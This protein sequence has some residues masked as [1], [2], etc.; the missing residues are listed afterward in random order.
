MKEEKKMTCAVCIAN[1]E[2]DNAAVLTM[3]HYGHPRLLCKSCEELIE[4]ALR[5]KEPTEAEAAM[6]RLGE[7]VGNNSI[8][9]EAVTEA[10]EDVFK[11]ATERAE[12]IKNGTYDFAL[13]EVEDNSFDEIP[14]E[15]LET[16]EE[17]AEKEREEKSNKKFDKVMD[18]VTAVV[19][20]AAFVCLLIFILK[21]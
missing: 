20:V 15:L 8:D 17:K 5:S 10:V 3:G 16:E 11:I 21:R 2:D 1:I 18:I 14:E 7:I 19:F 6:A 4:T 12:A 9:D 13:D